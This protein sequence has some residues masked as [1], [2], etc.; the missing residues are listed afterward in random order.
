MLIE[1]Q[2]YFFCIFTA[3]LYATSLCAVIMCPSVRPSQVGVLPRLINLG[4]R[5]QRHTIAQG[6]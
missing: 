5:K 6:L 3:R 4:S 1:F 2:F